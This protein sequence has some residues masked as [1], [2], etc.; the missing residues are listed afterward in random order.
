MCSQWRAVA[1]YYYGD[2]YPL[3]AYNTREDTWAAFQFDRPE[4]G[5]GMVQAFPPPRQPIRI[6]PASIA[7]LAA[8]RTVYR[9][10]P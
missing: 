2:Y 7:R 8:R 9:D 1:Q 6:S 3:T 5:D 4:S 10:R